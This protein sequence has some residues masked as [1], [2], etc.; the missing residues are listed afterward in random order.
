LDLRRR[1]DR[2]THQ[3]LTRYVRRAGGVDMGLRERVR[4]NAASRVCAS[5]S[6]TQSG[7]R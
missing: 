2:G 7:M 1:N 4:D 5:W 6:E 3:T